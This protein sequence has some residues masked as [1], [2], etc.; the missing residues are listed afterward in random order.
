MA[1][2]LKD[3]AT[4]TKYEPGC[5]K[6]LYRMN[7]PTTKAQQRVSSP[8]R[9]L[10]A[11]FMQEL[12]KLAGVLRSISSRLPGTGTARAKCLFEISIAAAG[13]IALTPVLAAIGLYCMH[14]TGG[15]A[16]LGS[17]MLPAVDWLSFTGAENMLKYLFIPA[18][19]FAVTYGLTPPVMR[20]AAR[21]G[22][23]DQPGVRRIH[24]RPVPR[25]G[26]IAVFA[27]FHIACACIFLFS[28]NS[29]SGLLTEAGWL[30][31]L[32]L[33]SLLL[34][35]G[36]WD[37]RFGMPA[38]VK[39]AGQSAVGALA[40]MM[41]MHLGGFFGIELPIW[42][43]LPATVFWFVAFINAFNLID[44]MDGL[45]TGLAAIAALGLA[46]VC[47]IGHKPGDCL[48]MLAL[49]GAC[50]AFLR[51]NFN[52]ARIFLGDTGSMFL[53]CTL[54]ALA[55]NTST[56]STTVAA[57]AVPLLAVGIPMFDTFLAVWRRVARKFLN[58]QGARGGQLF[59]A[60]IDHLHHRLLKAGL[61]QR[62]VVMLLYAGSF[63]L[64]GISLLAILFNSSAQGIYMIAFVIG[65]YI[66]IEHIATVEMW[67]TGMALLQGLKRPRFKHLS[68]PLYILCD[69]LVLLAA[70]VAA[71]LLL[72]HEHVTW[73]VVRSILVDQAPLHVGI[74]FVCMAL[75]GRVYK[76]VWYLAGTMDF[77]AL[78]AWAVMGILLGAGI[79]FALGLQCSSDCWLQA[80]LLYVGLALVPLLCLHA[81]M[82]I[83]TD[84]LGAMQLQ[85][86]SSEARTPVLVYGSG[87]RGM[88]FMRDEEAHALQDGSKLYIAGFLDDN[89]NLHGRL[90]Y[91]LPVFGG[92][93]SIRTAL[94]KT[95]AK[96]IVVTTQLSAETR[97]ELQDI[98]GTADAAV[99]EW[100]P[101]FC[102]VAQKSFEK[103]YYISLLKK[104]QS[105]RTYQGHAYANADQALLSPGT[106]A[107]EESGASGNPRRVLTAS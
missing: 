38:V 53:G 93:E 106:K 73:R 29:F 63:V 94:E 18:L 35:V 61:S 36:L 9:S 16:R 75:G 99:S 54:A 80:T 79:S 60:D 65:F 49:L 6:G 30:N 39:L 22:I 46:G 72:D 76:R 25:A 51:F 90:V 102:D 84:F 105:N 23:I 28:G 14:V 12:S 33:T 7:T 97:E 71:A 82:R 70:Y 17:T 32:L 8:E 87:H 107:I 100:R 43:D 41:D 1:P 4:Y 27:G 11:V 81:F 62:R 13:L 24:A 88:L 103:N 101:A 86:K 21:L 50:L 91:G 78:G 95:A 34:C 47:I 20:L 66:I 42:I 68:V 26:G 19:A 56:K 74:P 83:I 58:G 104:W 64:A 40:Y 37:D 92:L 69:L 77:T 57:V 96:L 89:T 52:P 3:H 48:V 44:G 45:A 85:G 5:V 2:L 98:A 59:G 15:I 10:G 67:T 55:L 31:I